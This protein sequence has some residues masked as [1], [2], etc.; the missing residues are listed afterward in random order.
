MRMDSIMKD[1][2]KKY[3]M[4]IIIPIGGI[5]KRF[6]DEGFD[7]PKPLISVLGKPMIYRVIEN[8]DLKEEDKIHI[9]Y[10]PELNNFRFESFLRKEFPKINFNFICLSGLTKGAAETILFGLERISDKILSEDFLIMDCDTFYDDN[11]LE[12]Y[13]KCKNKNSIFYFI[14]EENDPIFSYI[15]IDESGKVSDIKEKIKISKFANTGA[16]GFSS[17]VVLKEYCKKISNGERELYVS[18]IYQKMLEDG[19]KINSEEIEKFNCVGTPLQLKIYCETCNSYEKSRICF[20]LDNTLVTFPKISKDYTTV[21]PIQKNIDYLNFLKD[22]GNYIIIYTARRMKTH[23]GNVGRCISDIGKITIETLD[24]F[25]IKYDELH[26]GKPNADFYIDDLSV[27][28]FFGID[29]KIGFYDTGIVPRSF[30]KVDYLEK[31]VIKETNNPGEIYFY[32][33]LP[34][35][36]RDF[37]PEIHSIEKNKISMERIKGVNY[38]YLYTNE[39]LREKDLQDLIDTLKY[40]HSEGKKQ[41][42]IYSNYSKKL[43]KRY[44][45]NIQ[46]YKKIEDSSLIYGSIIEKI[47]KYENERKGKCGIIH[48]DP[49]FTNVF[50][51]ERK[52]KF[53]DPRGKIGESLSIYGDVY[54]DFSKIFQSILGYDHILNGY[55]IN[56]EYRDRMIEY[57]FS[58]FSEEEISNIKIITASLFFTLIPLHEF[59]EERFKKYF[60]I[61]KKLI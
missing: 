55:E 50:L 31:S 26:F 38:S 49:V 56:Y 12:K 28:A 9:I 7:L 54:Y 37:F 58:N 6:K 27:P 17:G 15:T 44:T 10:N 47:K 1:L 48:G 8:L 52:I 42:D 35:I 45:E 32:K 11:I 34:E 60:N 57:F 33:N 39:A 3:R 24:K 29:K 43:E 22:K 40:I 23:S 20:D 18:L 25:G 4:N 2:P 14:D 5:G 53:I 46:I 41:E 51:T 59:S 30:N 13:R 19:I 16:Y 21:D 36:I 61:I